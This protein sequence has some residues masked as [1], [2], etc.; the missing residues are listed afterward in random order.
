MVDI[1]L[2]MGLKTR[3][4]GDWGLLEGRSY[5]EFK[6]SVK[7]P[8]TMKTYRHSLIVFLSDIGMS[9]DQFVD[10]AK[11]DPAECQEIIQGFILKHKRRWDKE[12]ISS[13]TLQNY[14]KPIKT[15]LEMNDVLLVNWKKLNRLLPPSRKASLDRAPTLDEIRKVDS[16]GDQRLKFMLAV[17]V[18]SGIRAGAWLEMK[19]GHIQP[20]Y[21]DGEVVAGKLLVYPRSREQYYTFISPEA[22][23]RFEDYLELRR[24][25]SE[26]VTP[27]S[28][29]LRNI[30]SINA[31][32]RIN[33]R[34]KK[35]TL[36]K[37]A[38]NE[39]MSRSWR[40][41]GFRLNGGR[42]EVKLL[43][44]FRKF[45]KT[46]AEQVMRPINVETLLGH[47]TGVSDSYYRPLE[48][49]LLQDYLKAV[50]LLTISESEEV[51]RGLEF[52]L[53]EEKELSRELAARLNVLEQT[54]KDIKKR[55]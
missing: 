4:R 20:V 11:A 35:I 46:R 9:V 41:A 13:S 49:E 8:F 18:S 23:K 7:S 48:K 37:S 5:D 12:E 54:V 34:K 16:Y 25:G 40:K 42:H 55:I 3:K 21:Q 36:T 1:P 31:G 6:E 47:S 50:P 53:K 24:K 29:A 10:G 14:L 27:D 43:H 33:A 26:D 30:I 51:K 32:R 19:V 17:M 44:S 39:I 28:P 38:I 15:L 2:S 45:F 22:L 52:E